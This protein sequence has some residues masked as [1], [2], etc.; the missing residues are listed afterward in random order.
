MYKHICPTTDPCRGL[1][2]NS[3]TSPIQIPYYEVPE[4]CIIELPEI[5]GICILTLK[6][7]VVNSDCGE[8]E[9]CCTGNCG[10]KCR[11]LR[12]SNTP[13]FTIREEISTAYGPSPPE[14][15]YIPSC[16]VIGVY[17]P[18]QC[19][20]F[21][22]HCWCVDVLTGEPSGSFSLLGG[23]EVECASKSQ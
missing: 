9:K 6:N 21:V 5:F 20:N 8:G 22:R 10:R 4:I 3:C 15:T 12:N 17:D 13:C 16:Q 23:T 1:E 19:D 11:P 18:V 14:S 7:C 2:C